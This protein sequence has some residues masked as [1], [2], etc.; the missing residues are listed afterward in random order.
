[1][2]CANSKPLQMSVATLKTQPTPRALARVFAPMSDVKTRPDTAEE[3]A[4]VAA[5]KEEF[6]L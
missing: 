5:L 4:N 3:A 6:A 1:M 2:G